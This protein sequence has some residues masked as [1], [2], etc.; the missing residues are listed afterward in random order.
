MDTVA[1]FRNRD[2]RSLRM[3]QERNE[4]AEPSCACL[5]S[6]CDFFSAR[7]SVVDSS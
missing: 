7:P 4:R 6:R 5:V 3:R 1:V 2:Y